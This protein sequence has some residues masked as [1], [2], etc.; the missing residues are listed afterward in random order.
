MTNNYH[1]QIVASPGLN[2]GSWTTR[3]LDTSRASLSPSPTP[4]SS[5]PVLPRHPEGPSV[6]NTSQNTPV[7][8]VRPIPRPRVSIQAM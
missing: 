6:H 5:G 3:P 4:V 8:T 7:G 1:S 2:A